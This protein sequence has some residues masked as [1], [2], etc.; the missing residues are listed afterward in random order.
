M[1]PDRALVLGYYPEGSGWVTVGPAQ[2]WTLWGVALGAATYAYHL[3]R[4][5]T[6]QTCRRP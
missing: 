5:G 3:R 1:D 4:R 2:L 6:C